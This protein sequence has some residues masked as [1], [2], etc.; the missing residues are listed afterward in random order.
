MLTP[1]FGLARVDPRQL[2]ALLVMVPYILEPRA[3]LGFFSHGAGFTFI[4]STFVV[5]WAYGLLLGTFYNPLRDQTAIDSAPT[6]KVATFN[7]GLRDSVSSSTVGTR[8][9][10]TG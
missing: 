7:G 6:V 2:F 1:G 5:H 9:S 10:E 8:L 4:L 3:H